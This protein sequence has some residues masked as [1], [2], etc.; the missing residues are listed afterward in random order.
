MVLGHRHPRY[1]IDLNPTGISMTDEFQF[2]Y[3]VTR[4]NPKIRDRDVRETLLVEDRTNESIRSEMKR[5]AVGGTE[6]R[7]VLSIS[8]FFPLFWFDLVFGFAVDWM[9]CVLIGVCKFVT[10]DLFLDSANKDEEYYVGL[11]INEINERLLKITPPSS[12]SWFPR[13]LKERAQWK[14]NEWRMWLLF[15]SVVCLRGILKAPYLKHII[16]YW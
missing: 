16:A 5:V 15:Y 6:E 10:N 8:P 14:A 1:I 7:G 3:E 4:K 12:V 11:R 2:V 13:S 9:H